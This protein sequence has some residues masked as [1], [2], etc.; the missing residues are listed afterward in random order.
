MIERSGS[1]PARPDRFVQ[2]IPQETTMTDRTTLEARATELGIK[3]TDGWKDTTLE[4]R[5]AA[6]EKTNAEAEASA[7]VG[8][9]IT[10]EIEVPKDA[11]TAQNDKYQEHSKSGET[12]TPHSTEQE[13]AELLAA[14]ADLPEETPILPDPMNITLI[15]YVDVTGPAKGR[16]RIGKHFTRQTQR[17]AL[18]DLKDGQLDALEADPELA[19]T[20]VPA[21]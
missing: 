16:W 12:D 2:L 11:S 4:N 7:G 5:I 21:S 15:G 8:E 14:V 17:I 18:A 1:R 6:Q 13:R 9:T 19:V 3:F 20:V 10:L